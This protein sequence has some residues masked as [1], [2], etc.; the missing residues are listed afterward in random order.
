MGNVTP[1]QA[2]ETLTKF[3]F[4]MKKAQLDQQLAKKA[5][6]ALGLDAGPSSAEISSCLDEVFDLKEVWEAVSKPFSALVDVK[7][8]IWANAVMRKV[9]KTLDDLLIDLR[10][11]PNRI[12]QYDACTSLYD[13]IKSLIAGHAT[14]NDMKTDALKDRHWKT[15]LQRLNIDV[16]FSELTVGM[17]WD[18]GL[19]ERKKEM[20]EILQVSQGEMA[21]ENFLTEVRDRWMKQELDLVLYHVVGAEH[22]KEGTG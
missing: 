22:N 10:S 17:L 16:S 21:I 14:L 1:D 3:E 20:A 7:E 5:K 11:L 9:R 2:I 8:T 15:I 13:K 12:R 18:N 4:N 19:L 6:D